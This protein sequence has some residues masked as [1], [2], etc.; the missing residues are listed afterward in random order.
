[1]ARTTDAPAEPGPPERGSV[2]IVVPMLDEARLIRA[3]VARLRR[4]PPDELIIVDGGS[5]DGGLERL[6]QVTP[7]PRQRLLSAAGGLSAQ[8]NLG[9]EHACEEV[10]LFHYADAV[11]PNGWRAEIA[12]TLARPDVV[13]GCFPLRIGAP[14]GAFRALEIAANLRNRFLL[15][16]TGDQAVFVRRSA[17]HAVGGFSD[18]ELLEDVGFARRLRRLGRIRWC[19]TPVRS[20]PRR[21]EQGGVLRTTLSHWGY[22]ARHFLGSASARRREA[23]RRFRAARQP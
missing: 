7:L 14:G 10:I 4:D 18:R 21:W 8:L 11:L 1:M 12:R 3:L 23:Y 9:A 15:G 2:S 22:L 5:T 19:Q 6:A 17:F 20:S 16:P 13:A